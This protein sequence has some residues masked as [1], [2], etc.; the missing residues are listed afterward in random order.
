M[1]LGD[2]TEVVSVVHGLVEEVAV[3]LQAGRVVE[4]AEDLQEVA[5][6]GKEDPEG[7]GGNQTYWQ[8]FASLCQ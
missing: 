5:D 3:G 8:N 2:T 1:P 7:A 6:P 4:V